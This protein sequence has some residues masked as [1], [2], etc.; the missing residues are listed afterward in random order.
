VR[1]LGG[2][3]TAA[4]RG[5][6]VWRPSEGK[7]CDILEGIREESVSWH[8]VRL[9]RHQG[10]RLAVASR[11]RGIHVTLLKDHLPRNYFLRR[12]ERMGTTLVCITVF[13]LKIKRLRVTGLRSVVALMRVALHILRPRKLKV[14]LL[15]RHSFYG[16]I[17]RC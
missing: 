8:R 13:R 17:N 12:R 3:T 11:T 14:T 10:R 4:E 16:P 1:L 15:H 6:K 2:S 5:I 9:G 7:G